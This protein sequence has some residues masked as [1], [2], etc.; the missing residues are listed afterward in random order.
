[1]SHLPNFPP[2]VSV[3]DF[4]PIELPS[5]TCATCGAAW[6]EDDDAGDGYDCEEGEFY[7][8]GECLQV[9][10]QKSYRLQ[11]AEIAGDKL[12]EAL[13]EMDRLSRCYKDCDIDCPDDPRVVLD[14]T[15]MRVKLF[16]EGKDSGWRNGLMLSDEEAFYVR[17]GVDRQLIHESFS[18]RWDLGVES[19]MATTCKSDPWQVWRLVM[20]GKSLLTLK[21]AQSRTQ[22]GEDA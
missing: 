2:G 21:A 20:L 14:D 7:C 13:D 15:L 9:A 1:M 10:R 6:H 5:V 19:P 11:L 4:D 12:Q 16:A 17:S 18:V 3:D 8:V 22:E